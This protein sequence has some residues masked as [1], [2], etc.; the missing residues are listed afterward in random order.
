MRRWLTLLFASLTLSVIPAAAQAQRWA[1]IRSGTGEPSAE[2]QRARTAVIDALGGI[3][4]A[5][6]LDAEAAARVEDYHSAEPAAVESDRIEELRAAVTALE[7]HAALRHR[8]AAR[9]EAE[10]I[11]EL[12][13]GLS[14]ALAEQSEVAERLFAA[15]IAEAWLHIQ[16]REREA[17]REGLQQCREL[18]PDADINPLVVAPPVV[19]MLREID[20]ELATRP[21]FA[22][23]L[24]D[25]PAGC[26]L[27]MDG[28]RRATAP[29][30]IGDIVPGAHRVEVL[31]T[32][33]R[34]RRIHRVI[35]GA[36][37]RTIALDVRFDDV[38]LTRP[39]IRGEMPEV[40]LDYAT[41][42]DERTHRTGDGATLGVLL[43]ATDVILVSR[44]RSGGLR[45]DRLEVA[46]RV[47]RA[48]VIV[49]PAHF[50]GALVSRAATALL[51]N[52]SVDLSSGEPVAIR[53]WPGSE[54][55][56]SDADG[57]SSEPSSGHDDGGLIAGLT[58]S[59]A[60]VAAI[61]VGW[62]TYSV[63]YDAG[64]AVIGSD[65]R[66]PDW[67]ANQDARASL[68]GASYGLA[69]GGAVLTTVGL[70]LWL[71]QTPGEV[72]WWSLVIGVAGLGAIV[73]AAVYWAADGVQYSLAQPYAS[74]DTELTGT[75]WMSMAA[76]LLAVPL[77][78]LIRLATDPTGIEGA[79]ASIDVRPEGVMVSV[80]ASF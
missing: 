80:G 70:P 3:G 66:N 68:M 61:G 69:L 33:M 77:I 49:D 39:A 38:L 9:M 51:E 18:H 27:R 5:I 59:I 24:A 26:E 78:Y 13:E 47:V 58:L 34:R 54:G 50:E 35:V 72:P 56:S 71:P 37:N 15:C 43:E 46:N 65:P 74:Y 44:D 4:V 20:T 23:T 10:R 29:S 2:E 14:T 31:C 11:R 63:A 17:A 28:R 48:S 52:R 73:P 64:Q 53:A 41:A 19:D 8:E 32:G 1:V 12:S 16:L 40:R 25:V 36:E 76:P 67:A 62:G 42:A 45:F 60:G 79:R 57:G 22:L 6:S 21:T 55:G 30:P 75:M 7:E